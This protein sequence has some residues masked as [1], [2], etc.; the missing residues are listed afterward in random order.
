MATAVDDRSDLKLLLA[1]DVL[2]S[3]GEARLA[4]SG[5]SMLPSLWPGD[6][7]EIHRVAADD[8]LRVTSWCSPVRIA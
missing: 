1:I 5:G 4:V 3:V 6:V 2:R 8:I 7:L